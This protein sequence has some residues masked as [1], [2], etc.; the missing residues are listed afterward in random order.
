MA[1]LAAHGTGA[2]TLP[3][4]ATHMVRITTHL[5][6]HPTRTALF[7]EPYTRLADEPTARSR[8]PVPAAARARDRLRLP[9]GEAAHRDA[10]S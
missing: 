5:E 3:E 7:T 1:A 6:P 9:S 2:G 10:S 8:L 4:I